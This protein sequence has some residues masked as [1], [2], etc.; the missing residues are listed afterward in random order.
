MANQLVNFQKPRSLSSAL[1]K[2]TAWIWMVA[3]LVS[4]SWANFGYAGC[5]AASGRVFDWKRD[6]L[7]SF[8][9]VLEASVLYDSRSDAALDALMAS[10]MDDHGYERCT[11]CRHRDNDSVPLQTD[12]T[13]A[14]TPT[15]M[16]R[17]AN[18]IRARLREQGGSEL[19][20]IS[21]ASFFGR[22]LGV[23]ERPPILA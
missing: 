12:L 15:Y 10:A 22:D 11:R 23:L 16:L 2:S 4:M 3:M 18:D 14:K 20:G 17:E 7:T 19:F 8:S 13:I 6:S 5:G 21:D 1:P 9:V